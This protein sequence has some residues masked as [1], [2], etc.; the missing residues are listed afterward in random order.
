MTRNCDYCKK[1]YSRRPSVIGKFCSNSCKGMGNK[2]Q[3]KNLTYRIPKGNTPWNKGLGRADVP[4][5]NCSKINSALISQK[6]RFCDKQC[7]NE[8]QTQDN[9]TSYGGVHRWVK[10]KFGSPSKCENCRTTSSKKFEWANISREYKLERS[11]WARLCCQCHRRYDFGV[12]N[13]IE[14]LNV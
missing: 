4:C 10:R 14:V 1:E 13:K 2:S 3:L 5:P 8:Y 12:E 9:P 11:D 7:F 6:A